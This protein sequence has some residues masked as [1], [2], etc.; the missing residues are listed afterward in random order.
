MLC[1]RRFPPPNLVSCWS[2][3]NKDTRRTE[4]IELLP[5]FIEACKIFSWISLR[6]KIF[7]LSNLAN[8]VWLTGLPGDCCCWCCLLLV[9]VV[10]SLS[11]ST[12]S[13]VSAAQLWS[14]SLS[15]NKT[16]PAGRP[17]V[18]LS[19]HCGYT[20]GWRHSTGLDWTASQHQST[21]G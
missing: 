14:R 9:V 19:L 13:P 10:K 1:W 21:T 2:S 18:L 5:A 16:R 7:F 6:D 11:A 15:S 4:S 20:A 8:I 12:Y 3:G 17:T